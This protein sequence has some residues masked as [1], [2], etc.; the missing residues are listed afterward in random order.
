MQRRAQDKPAPPQLTQATFLESWPPMPWLRPAKRQLL[1]RVDGAANGAHVLLQLEV[2]GI[3]Q[4]RQVSRRSAS[5]VEEEPKDSKTTR[6]ARA[7]RGGPGT[8]CAA[9]PWWRSRRVDRRPDSASLAHSP[10]FRCEPAQASAQRKIKEQDASAPGNVVAAAEYSRFG[11][12]MSIVEPPDFA[13]PSPPAVGFVSVFEVRVGASAAAAPEDDGVAGAAARRRQTF[14]RR[15]ARCVL[16]IE[17]F[18]NGVAG[19]CLVVPPGPSSRLYRLD[20]ELPLS[21]NMTGACRC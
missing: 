5:P 17:C 21:F 12:S 18:A 20:C 3:R 15:L 4:E 11:S 13:P 6:A 1:L 19:G 9:S 2:D 7:G 8:W 14:R 16:R 10:F